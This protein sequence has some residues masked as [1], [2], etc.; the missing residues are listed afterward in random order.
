[1][2]MIFDTH[3]HG[4]WR[5]L[6]HRRDEVRRNMQ[7]AGVVRSVHIGTDI[8]R[9]RDSLAL[10]RD[11]GADTWCTAGFHP[12]GCQDQPEDSAPG[13]MEQL[14][15]IIQGNRDKIV[16][17]GETG[18][19]YFHTT[20]DKKEAQKKAQQAFFRSHAALALRLDL[21]LIIHTRDAAADTIALIKESGIKR[22]VIH[23][24]SENEAFARELMAWSGEIYFSFSG[25]LTYKRS[26]A[27]QDAARSLPLDRILV[28]TD[29][30]FLVPQA[31][32]D[33]F[34]TN[35]PAFTRHTMDFLKSLRGEP[36]DAVEQA[37]WKNSNRFF[38]ISD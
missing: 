1:M 31:V 33:A 29:A 23:C 25:I 15:E 22:A 9:S 6:A 13:Y 37:V 30:P 11:W 28:E 20:R 35:E 10:A 5:G 36:G 24:F 4:Y 19:D 38:R 34:S 21:P 14:E 7:S 8:A 17:I 27:I 3:C 2:N 12:T 32:P 16:G 18:L 26:V